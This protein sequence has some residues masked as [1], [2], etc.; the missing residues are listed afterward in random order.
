[1]VF[2]VD[3]K[4][5]LRV[6]KQQKSA[7]ALHVTN[8]QYMGIGYTIKQKFGLVVLRGVTGYHY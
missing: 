8:Y 3:K 7:Y 5:D 6:E 4:S 1:M 2:W